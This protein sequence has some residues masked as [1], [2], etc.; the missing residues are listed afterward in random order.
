MSTCECGHKHDEHENG[1][2]GCLAEQV[3][4]DGE[5]RWPCPCVM[6]DEAEDGNQA[7]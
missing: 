1:G 2:G 5:G 6:F 3:S 4:P 7:P